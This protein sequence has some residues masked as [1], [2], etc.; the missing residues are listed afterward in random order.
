MKNIT[1]LIAI[2]T[3]QIYSQDIVKDIDVPDKHYIISANY[4]KDG[5]AVIKTNKFSLKSKG[6]EAVIFNFDSELNLNYRINPKYRFSFVSASEGAKSVLYNNSSIFSSTKKF[7]VLDEKGEEKIYDGKE[8]LPKNFILNSFFISDNEFL[9]L[10]YDKARR[11][12]KKGKSG[13]YQLFKRSL[14]DFTSVNTIEFSLPE[15]ED[16]SGKKS[17]GYFLVD[18]TDDVFTLLTKDVDTKK[19][20]YVIAIYSYNGK[21]LNTII[22]NE[23]INDEN[24]F[25]SD[26]NLDSNSYILIS[27]TN[28]NSGK[29][30]NS[31]RKTTSAYGSVYFDRKDKAIYTYSLYS[32]KKSKFGSG[33]ILNKYSLSGDL[34]WTSKKEIFS[35]KTHKEIDGIKTIVTLVNTNNN[36]GFSVTNSKEDYAFTYNI[37]KISGKVINSLAYNELDRLNPIDDFYSIKDSFSKKI[38]LDTDSIIAT[39]ISN[40]VK[41]YFLSLSNTE[42]KLYFKSAIVNDG[43]IMTQ[44]DNKNRT[45]KL[46]KFYW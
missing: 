22:L 23:N 27:S 18:R 46:L 25:L 21:L 31:Y 10:G 28:A 17:R 15:F 12:I 3:T 6:S 19:Q 29:S 36:L 39:S 42:S 4:T 33:Y 32:S 45:F 16:N 14:K 8:W 40:K 34:L 44:V 35:K 13:T 9:G 37:D 1:L 43:I 20:K 26:A 30:S 7:N 5:S 11:D 2:I 24:Q 41:N 38:F